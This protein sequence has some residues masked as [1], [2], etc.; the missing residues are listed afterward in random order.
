[1]TDN[2]SSAQVFSPEITINRDQVIALRQAGLAKSP[3]YV[4]I[5]LQAEIGL[6]NEPSEICTE[7]FCKR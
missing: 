5:C 7:D 6:A 3:F 4:W 2:S 1:M